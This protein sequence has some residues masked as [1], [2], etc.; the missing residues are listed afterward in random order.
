[1]PSFRACPRIQAISTK[2]LDSRFRG[3]DKEGGISTMLLN[4]G[5]TLYCAP[6]LHV[7]KNK[8]MKD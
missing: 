8:G 2:S 4:R 7:L 1:M 3:Y 6:F 5:E